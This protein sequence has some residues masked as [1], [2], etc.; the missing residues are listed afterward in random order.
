MHVA[1]IDYGSGNLR[2]VEKAFENVL[3]NL[4]NKRVKVTSNPKD[5]GDAS[6]IVLPGVGAFAACKSKLDS[7]DGMIEELNQQVIEKAKPFLGICVGMQLLANTGKEH[8]ATN[9]FGWI[10]GEVI[11]IDQPS[12]N[13]KVPHMGWNSL[14]IESPH[15]L[16]SSL[17]HEPDAYFVHSY[18][19]LVKN[20]KNVIATFHHGCFMAAIVVHENIVGT[21]FHPEKSQAVG[22]TFIKNFLRW[23]P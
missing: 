19:F 4:G 16:L 12:E 21:Q 14:C 7:I 9:G 17:E 5:L 8:K 23:N 2:S 22:L 10:P 20:P 3:D 15:S 1:V 13:I 11:K 18:H 6:H